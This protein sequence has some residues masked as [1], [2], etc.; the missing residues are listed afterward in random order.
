VLWTVI[1]QAL[2][3]VVVVVVV[4]GLLP[5]KLPAQVHNQTP[6][7]AFLLIEYTPS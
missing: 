2:W 5:C 3:M 1:R 4:G 7:P 6:V